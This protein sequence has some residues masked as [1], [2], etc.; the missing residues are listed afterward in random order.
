SVHNLDPPDSPRRTSQ[1][2]P[3]CPKHPNALSRASNERGPTAAEPLRPP[4]SRRLRDHVEG[5]DAEG[6]KKPQTIV[7][8]TRA[9]NLAVSQMKDGHSVVR[10][11]P[12][13]H[14]KPGKVTRMSS[15]PSPFDGDSILLGGEI[16]ERV[17]DVRKG[18]QKVR[19]RRRECCRALQSTGAGIFRIDELTQHVEFSRIET[20]LEQSP[21]G[22]FVLLFAF[23]RHVLGLQSIF[24]GF[25]S[26]DGTQRTPSTSRS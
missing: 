12:T 3:P 23:H 6:L 26:M 21:D 15:P 11:G 2:S 13:R 10:H 14:G 7:L 16:F 1:T 18:S 4:R 20:L 5:D 22:L 17:V 24:R 8:D 9:R 25:T 19:D